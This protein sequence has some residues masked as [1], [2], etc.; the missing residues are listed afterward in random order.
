M[1]AL[2][3]AFLKLPADL[4]K[5]VHLDLCERALLVWNHY[6]ETRDPLE[7]VESV[8]GTRRIVDGDLPG[9]AIRAVRAGEDTESVAARY[10]EPIV[11]MQDGDL[12]FPAEVE[13]AYYAIYNLFQRQ[14]TSRLDD[15]WLIV[16]QALSA[17][18]ESA[19]HAGILKA[20]MDAAQKNRGAGVKAAT[21]AG[22]TAPEARSN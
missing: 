17:R 13:F 14:V 2:A 4:K 3:N 16:N 21:S 10:R 22:E 12:G 11:A 20:A 8:C 1:A 6:R 18:G 7:Y 19:D 5:A 15:D 9:A